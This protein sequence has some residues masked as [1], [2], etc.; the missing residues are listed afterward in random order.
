MEF[1]N[2]IDQQILTPSDT[3]DS[4]T[5]GLRDIFSLY[6]E[7][8]HWGGDESKSGKGSSKDRG[9][10]LSSRLP[11]LIAHTDAESILDV[12]CGDLNWMSE[13]PLGSMRY[14]G[15]DIVPQIIADNDARYSDKGQFHCL[16]ASVD[17]LPDADLIFCR[18]MLIHLPNNHIKNFLRNIAKSS[19]K[20]FICS[21]YLGPIGPH[22]LNA[23]IAAGD[24]RA[25][26]LCEPPF[27]LPPPQAMVP[28]KVHKWKT[29]A[30]WSVDVVRSH[31]QCEI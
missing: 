9:D 26:D 13:F 21:R 23:D 18:D 20:W 6:Y 24:F 30:L 4:L 19:A 16:D 1:D 3:P 27:N 10:F 11:I 25:V 22:E 14:I 7:T 29:L 31:S 17:A 28:E 2:T 8:N 12:P 5:S 15:A